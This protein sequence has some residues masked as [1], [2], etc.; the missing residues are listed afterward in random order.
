LNNFSGFL[1]TKARRETAVSPYLKRGLI[2]KHFLRVRY[3]GFEIICEAGVEVT[4]EAGVSIKP[5][6]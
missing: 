4:C 3:P 1:A 5:G 2:V 6:A